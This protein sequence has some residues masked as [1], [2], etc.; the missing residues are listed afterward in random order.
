MRLGRFLLGLAVIAIALW[1]LLGEQ[2]TGVSSDAVVN[3]RLMTIRA[4][5]DGTLEMP[6]QPF[7]SFIYVGL[8]LATVKNRLVDTVR[9]HDLRMERA[10]SAAEVERLIAFGAGQAQ[11]SSNQIIADPEVLANRSPRTDSRIGSIELDVYLIEARHRLAAMDIRIAEANERLGLLGSARLIAPTY[12]ALWEVLADHGEVV[13]RGQEVLKVMLCNT[14]IVT[15]SVP[16]TVY[17]RLRVGQTAKF[18]LNGTQTLYDATITRMAG[19]GASTIYRNLAV[20][21]SI[22]H[23]E[24]YDV[25]LLVPDLRKNTESHCSVGQTGRVFFDT[26]PLD[27]VRGLL[28]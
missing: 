9:L 16:D 19:A 15:L 1:V 8:E 2:I 20:A 12:G 17:N 4:P 28:N 13:Q 6:F 10:F 26:R 3:A 5:I 21:P 22:K 27:W 18:R 23:L 7:G 24:R 14:A 25:S 11:G